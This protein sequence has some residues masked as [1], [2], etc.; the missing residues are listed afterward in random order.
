MSIV[1]ICLVGILPGLYLRDGGQRSA[2]CSIFAVGIK[3]AN[4][5]LMTDFAGAADGGTPT[6][7]SGA[8]VDSG[9]AGD[10]DGGGGVLRSDSGVW[11]GSWPRRSPAPSGGLWPASHYAFVLPCVY[12]LWFGTARVATVR[13][14]TGRRGRR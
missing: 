4:T 5:V 3:V 12:S 1:P 9:E 14:D 11:A 6:R 8:G 2:A 10:D 13:A 7:R